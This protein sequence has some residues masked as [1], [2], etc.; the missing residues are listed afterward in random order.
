VE[1]RILETSLQLGPEGAVTGWAALRLAGATYFDGLRS[2]R[3]TPVPVLLAVGGPAGRRTRRGTSLSYEPLPDAERRALHGVPTT[4]PARAL[5]DEMRRVDDWR[6]AVVAM[7][8]AA[9]AELV[10]IRRMESYLAS[11]RSWRRSSL[12]QK[13]LPFCNERAW[14]PPESRLR[15]VWELDAGL[16]RPLVNQDVFGLDGRR[17]CVADLFDP[18]A[19]LVVEYDGAEH[20][21]AGRHSR[22]VAREER[23]RAVGLEYCK[24]TGP[25]MRRDEVVVER[26][27]AT[28]GRAKFLSEGARHW[29]LMPPPGWH[30]PE[31]LD[32]L[33]D[34]REWI[35][36]RMEAEHGLRPTGW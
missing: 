10:S 15:L 18:A 11:H 35:A 28:R 2:D 8:M 3:R 17:I 4:V 27:L 32:D 14:S 36:D 26:L 12:V 30:V 29:T 13:A 34:R 19:G 16:P 31:P 23:C 20:R 5:F 24:V 21:K 9:A 7:D 33:L 1:Q 22:D 25:D 6:E